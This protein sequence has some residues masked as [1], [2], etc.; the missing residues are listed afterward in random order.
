MYQSCHELET[1]ENVMICQQVRRSS[2]RTHSMAGYQWRCLESR[3]SAFLPISAIPL[4]PNAGRSGCESRLPKAVIRSGRFF[5][6]RSFL[7]QKSKVL[8]HRTG[9]N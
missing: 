7:M 1:A 2:W 4:S 8:H 3:R 5:S 9:S 6:V